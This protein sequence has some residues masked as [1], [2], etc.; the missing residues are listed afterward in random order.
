[1]FL[2]NEFSPI[3]KI[4]VQ[5]LILNGS[6]HITSTSSETMLYI[7]N[8]IILNTLIVLIIQDT[9]HLRRLYLFLLS[10]SS[11]L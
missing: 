11:L 3:G 9:F 8:I 5:P 4:I 2:N 10:K 1:M 6:V 7:G